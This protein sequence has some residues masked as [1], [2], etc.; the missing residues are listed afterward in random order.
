[1]RLGDIQ[2]LEHVNLYMLLIIQLG[3]ITVRPLYHKG[4]HH[5]KG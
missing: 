3:L 2:D 4:D 1:M 5:E